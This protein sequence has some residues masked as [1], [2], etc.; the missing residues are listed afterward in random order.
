VDALTKSLERN[1]AVVPVVIGVHVAPPFVERMTV[2]K[3]PTAQTW[4]ASVAVTQSSWFVV[5]DVCEV[6]VVPPLVV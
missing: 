3:Y 2:P 1:E 4:L 6:H 5:P